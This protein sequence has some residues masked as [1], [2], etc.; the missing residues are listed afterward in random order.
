MI[1]YPFNS[2]TGCGTIAD[3][4]SA[5][6]PGVLWN[7]TYMQAGPGVT[8]GYQTKRRFGVNIKMYGWVI[9]IDHLY[10]VVVSFDD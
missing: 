4:G 9:D 5:F 10:L 3:A 1:L 2:A 6:N 7:T 8:L